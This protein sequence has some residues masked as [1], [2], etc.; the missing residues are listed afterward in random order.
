[1][2]GWKA[3]AV[4]TGDSGFEDRAFDVLAR[5]IETD[6]VQR[7]ARY[8]TQPASPSPSELE[9]HV[10]VAVAAR[11][12]FGGGW[13]DTPPYSIERGGTVL[14]AAI[15]LHDRHPIIAE[16]ARTP[17]PGLV[18]A[19][20]DINDVFIPETVGEV[21]AY[22]NPADP[23]ALL[24]AAL[25]VKGVVPVDC[26]PDTPISTL[27]GSGQGLRLTTQTRIPRGS[28]LGTSSII[29]GAVLASLDNLFG[30]KSPPEELFDQVLCLEQM[31]TTGGGWQDQVGGLTGGVKL[32]TT[33]PGA[34][35]AHP[36][37]AAHL[38]REYNRSPVP[39]SGADLHR[40]AAPR[41]EL[42]PLRHGTLDGARSGDGLVAR[43]NWPPGHC[44][45]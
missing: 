18:L 12:D 20:R 4:A 9:A 27:L 5:Q 40:T 3:L 13:T 23:F 19:S 42:A 17:E 7:Q 25:V 41:Q 28:G 26:R 43:G 21:L 29:A 45:A 34:S 33:A 35:A 10:R 24:K 37:G 14:N 15:L 31:L 11:I 2:R 1:M 39:A 32:L 36:G 16:A 22:R 30:I 38:Q 8:R 44:H 6:V